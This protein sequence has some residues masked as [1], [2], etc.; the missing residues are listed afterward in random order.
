MANKAAG[1]ESTPIGYT[2]HHNED[3]QTMQLIPT[4]LHQAIR[5]SGGVSLIK[6]LLTSLL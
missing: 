3:M 6:E 5:H 2:W 4:D 1:L